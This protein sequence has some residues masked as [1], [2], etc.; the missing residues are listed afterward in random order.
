MSK[1]VLDVDDVEASGV[2][3]TVDEG[4]D[5]T[6]VTTSS[7]HDADSSLKLDEVGDA[8]SGKV[9]LDGVVGLDEG[10]GVADRASVVG[11]NVWHAV[12]YHA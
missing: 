10:V 5:T 4:S 11:H 7:D 3:L 9:D 12:G 8:S 1:R 6:S 2:L